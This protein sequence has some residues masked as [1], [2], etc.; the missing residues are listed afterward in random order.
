MAKTKTQSTSSFTS[1]SST[2]CDRHA[3]SGTS[4]NKRSKNYKKSYKGQGR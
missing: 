1:K 4:K 3:K 2:S